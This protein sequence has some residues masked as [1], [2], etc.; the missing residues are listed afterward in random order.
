MR[1]LDPQ[2]EDFSAENEPAKSVECCAR[3]L[4]MPRGYRDTDTELIEKALIF[5][6]FVLRH[7]QA[8]SEVDFAQTGH[9][10]FASIWSFLGQ[11]CMLLG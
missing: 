11:K 8:R 2:P 5:E 6:I 9:R 7:F 4:R 1:L 10:N 3:A